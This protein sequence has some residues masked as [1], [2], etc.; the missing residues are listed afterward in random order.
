MKTGLIAIFSLV[1][2]VHTCNAAT[3]AY[4]RFEEGTNGVLAA[5]TNSIIDRSGHGLNAT[6]VVP[7]LY[8]NNVPVSPILSNK[9]SLLFNGNSTRIFIPDYPQLQLTNSLTLEAF[10]MA[11]SYP[12]SSINE[13]QIIFRGDD[14]IGRDPYFIEL[15]DTYLFFGISPG[16]PL[17]SV[18]A[19]ITLRQWHHVAGTLDGSTGNMRLYID[20]NL[21]ASTNTALRP[22][23]KLIG[24]NPGL[25]IGNVQSGNYAEYFNGFID[26]A[27][28]SDVALA[29]SQFLNSAPSL[30]MNVP[31]LNS[32]GLLLGFD[33]ISGN[34]QLFLLLQASQL[35]GPWITNAGAILATNGSSSFSFQVSPAGTAP[36]QF[37]RIQ[38]R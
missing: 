12:Q 23:Q 29:P 8:S 35:S 30:K 20:G 16:E 18:Q 13:S 36:A 1:V 3:V 7:P 4:Y 2:M 5:G 31:Q 17:V 24:S 34:P 10:I 26:E 32:N 38:A 27:R 28:I 11:L 33:V 6:P 19:P 22:Y 9:L 37:Y 25:G 14:E 15:R 21:V